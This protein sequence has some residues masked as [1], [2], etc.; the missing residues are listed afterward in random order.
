MA[1]GR[2]DHTP[3]AAD[4][5][6][7]DRA[8]WRERR[9]AMAAGSGIAARAVS[10]SIMLV[11]V[12]VTLA[13]LG[14][15]P[16]GFVATLTAVAGLLAFADLGIG[17]G[18]LNAVAS[19]DGRGDRVGI[20]TAVSSGLYTMTALAGILGIIALVV[21]PAV[22]WADLLGARNA[23][24]RVDATTAMLAL[25]LAT[26]AGMPLACVS[27]SRYGLQQGYVENMFQIGGSTISLVFVLIAV[28]RDAGLPMVVLAVAAGP[29]VGGLID[30]AALLHSRP[31][32]RPR[33]TSW[34]R[35]SAIYLL[36]I[37]LGFLSLQ[38]ALAVGFTTDTI[39]LAR[40]LGPASVAQ[41]SVAA[42]LFTI[43]AL[44]VGALLIPLWPA[45]REASHSGDMEWVGRTFR[46]SRWIALVAAAPTSLI[47][48]VLIG[49]MAGF[50]TGGR[51]TVELALGAGLAA[52]TIAVALWNA[53]GYLFNAL[54]ELRFMVPATW[55]MAV[56]N[57]PL[58]IVLTTVVGVSG[59]AWGSAVAV[60]IC[61][62]VPSTI[63]LG[64][65]LRRHDRV[66]GA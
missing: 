28:A 9:A 47:L 55:L 39:I 16:Y 59:V 17:K 42:R 5:D 57:L 15:A 10:F 34:D 44:L 27:A 66:V 32:F 38:V 48:A 14:T 22:D 30:G 29:L 7:Q 33:P 45:Y 61:L 23:V 20:N 4:R 25:V 65:A 21:I 50:W 36:R 3:L 24:S 31:W 62:L 40:L 19:A 53:Y 35:G 26:L 11:T 58:S 2:S 1:D 8:S 52:S 60:S 63:Y 64:D 12:P 18:L 37:G 43:P 56:V 46:R 49:P 54:Q 6:A 13:Y 41:Y 51:V